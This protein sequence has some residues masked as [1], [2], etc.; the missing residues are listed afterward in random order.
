[1]VKRTTESGGIDEYPVHLDDHL[2]AFK[3]RSRRAGM[4]KQKYG[5]HGIDY[6]YM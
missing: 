6:R 1:M 4:F 5:R 3:E 2:A